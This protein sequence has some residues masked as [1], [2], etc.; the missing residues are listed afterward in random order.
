MRERGGEERATERERERERESERER[1][2]CISQCINTH[3][4]APAGN[5]W[6]LNKHKG[7]LSQGS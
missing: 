1:M 2:Y 5:A 6:A 3:L 7:S 4:L